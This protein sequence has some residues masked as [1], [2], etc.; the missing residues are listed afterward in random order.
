MQAE[1]LTRLAAS[2]RVQARALGDGFAV[3]SGVDSNAHNGV[4]CSVGVDDAAIADVVGWF[5]AA[6]VPAQ[7]L[8]DG[9][10]GTRAAAR[11]PPAAVRSARPW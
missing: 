9:R 10:L 4:V 2:S 7:W 5:Q 8:V 3:L 6:G 1:W 11:R